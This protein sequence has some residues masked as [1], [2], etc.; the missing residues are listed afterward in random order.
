MLPVLSVN[1]DER[2]HRRDETEAEAD[3]Q[4]KCL[5]ACGPGGLRRLWPGI[6]YIATGFSDP[7]RVI[8]GAVLHPA[9]GEDSTAL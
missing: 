2:H 5:M 9:A 6:T 8:F 3:H 1:D 4:K 7:A